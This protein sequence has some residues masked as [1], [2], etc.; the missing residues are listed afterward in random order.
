MDI[1]INLIIHIALAYTMV[2]GLAFT[3]QVIVLTI[4]NLI[5]RLPPPPDV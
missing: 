3:I 2:K 5:D 1:D 4:K